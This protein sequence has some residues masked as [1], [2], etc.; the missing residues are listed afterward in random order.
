MTERLPSAEAIG[1]FVAGVAAFVARLE[2]PS[3]PPIRSPAKG[4]YRELLRQSVFLIL[5]KSEDL[6]KEEEG[7]CLGL[8]AAVEQTLAAGA[9][10]HARPDPGSRH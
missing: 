3:G 7:D 9:N 5:Q 10:F 4:A 8:L 6:S 2:S 1:A